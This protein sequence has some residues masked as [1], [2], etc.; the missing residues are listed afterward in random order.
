MSNRFNKIKAKTDNMLKGYF[1]LFTNF[2]TLKHRN[3]IIKKAKKEI[4]EI[5]SD[6]KVTVIQLESRITVE[7]LMLSPDKAHVKN[8]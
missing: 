5:N 8:V 1:K 7:L 3:G 6:I 4:L 2:D